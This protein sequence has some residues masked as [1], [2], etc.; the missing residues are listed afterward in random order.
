[1]LLGGV[2]AL[3]EPVFDVAGC[4]SGGHDLIEAAA[5]IRPEVVVLDVSMPG[6]S[7]FETAARLRSLSPRTR[8]V[9]YSMHSSAVYVKRAFQEGASAWVLKSAIAEDLITAIRKTLAGER[10][11]SPS[12]GLDPVG[13][14]AAGPAKAS[15]TH[16]LTTRQLEILQLVADGRMSKEIAHIAGISIKTVDFH[17]ARLMERLG[18]HSTAELVRMAVEHGLIPAATPPSDDI[19]S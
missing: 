5:R 7:G 12:L 1:M 6:L 4:F 18:V 19:G 13:I 16:G 10:W 15:A 11:I 3:L 2:R 9:F 8:V 17:R 14:S